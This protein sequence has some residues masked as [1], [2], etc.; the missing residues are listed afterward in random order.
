MW[1]KSKNDNLIY[2]ELDI[3]ICLEFRVY[4]LEFFISEIKKIK[5]LKIIKYKSLIYFN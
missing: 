3:R 2:C 1:S 5:V 4:M